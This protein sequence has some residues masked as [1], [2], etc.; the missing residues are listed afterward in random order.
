MYSDNILQQNHTHPMLNLFLKHEEFQK[1]EFWED[2]QSKQQ[3]KQQT[4]IH[5][6]IYS[7]K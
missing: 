5:A 4:P 2:L 3:I 6:N 7:L 1:I